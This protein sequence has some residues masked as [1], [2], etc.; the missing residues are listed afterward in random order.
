MRSV[1]SAAFQAAVSFFL[2]GAAVVFGP[3]VALADAIYVDVAPI[4][5]QTHKSDGKKLNSAL[6]AAVKRV[7]GV[8]G[9]VTNNEENKASAAGVVIDGN[10]SPVSV[11]VTATSPPPAVNGVLQSATVTSGSDTV[12]VT[13]TGTKTSLIGQQDAD[14]EKTITK[15]RYNLANT[16]DLQG[17]GP[18]TLRL[19]AT[20]NETGVTTKADFVADDVDGMVKLLNSYDLSP[21][22]ADNGGPVSFIPAV[23]R[24]A[25]LIPITGTSDP[26]LL[27]II[28][29]A[30]ARAHVAIK[31]P[32][33]P[34]NASSSA[35]DLQKACAVSGVDAIIGW[36]AGTRTVPKPLGFE[37]YR[38][39]T[40]LQTMDCAGI[41]VRPT[42][43]GNSRI[44][45]P[46]NT[47]SSLATLGLFLNGGLPKLKINPGLLTVATFGPEL[48]FSNLSGS[49]FEGS[50]LNEAA[51][52]ATD[53]AVTRM[54][55]AANGKQ[56]LPK[57]S[58]ND[59]PEN[60]F[61]L[62]G[63]FLEP[64]QTPSPVTTAQYAACNAATPAKGVMAP[65]PLPPAPPSPTPAATATPLPT[66]AYVEYRTAE[67]R[68]FVVELTSSENIK[69]AS[70]FKVGDNKVPYFS[71][72]VVRGGMTYNAAWR[73]HID[74]ATVHFDSKESDS[75]NRPIAEVAAGQE[76][77]PWGA[78]FF[79]YFPTPPRPA[80]EPQAPNAGAHPSAARHKGRR[81]A[82]P[83]L[84]T[85]PGRFWY[86]PAI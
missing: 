28:S 10:G 79:K 39:E 75:C 31:I 6:L 54:C 49:Q 81:Q 51:I 21:L 8:V 70:H 42:V 37:S 68:S 56:L 7:G 30:L 72:T 1:R 3:S 9:R 57:E 73:W 22:F 16:F 17:A 52:R 44:D 19:I 80:S 58:T 61:G 43:R 25:L 66:V 84:L 83:L 33:D 46:T 78:R 20:N 47:L 15:A 11:V 48:T 34:V 29:R 85:R 32:T 4:A 64:V 59:K 24:S 12:V 50:M 82:S 27:P 63:T 40:A 23:P 2:G 77:C 13:G 65:C 26:S 18:I 5:L 35:T 14:P 71:G 53:S 76:W 55:A 41:K 38:A 62:C 45:R 69:A 74:P 60:D 36:A 86:R 67:G